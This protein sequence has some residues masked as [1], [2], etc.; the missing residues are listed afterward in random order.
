MIRVNENYLKLKSSYLFSEISRKV[1]AFQKEN[2]DK[3][4]I[5]LGIGDVTRALPP[6]CIE[7]FHAAVDEMANDS[8][9]GA[10]A[11]NR[12]MTFCGKKSLHRIFSPVER[13]SVLT[14]FSSVTGPSVIPVIFRS[15]FPMISPSQ[16]LILFT[17]FM[18]IPM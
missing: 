10:M 13:I 4:I 18:S 7:A 3:E 16:F 1:N 8:T 5:R 11:P 6:A 2:P 15:F 12:D 9:F 14:K 17:R